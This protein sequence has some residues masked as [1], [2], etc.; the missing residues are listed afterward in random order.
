VVFII[1]F[2]LSLRLSLLFPFFFSS[3]SA[4][5]AAA[6]AAI[7][8]I[9]SS[10]FVVC[11]CVSIVPTLQPDVAFSN[12][13]VYHTNL[14]PQIDPVSR[15][16]PAFVCCLVSAHLFSSS[17]SSLLVSAVLSLSFSFSLLSLVPSPL[18][19]PLISFRRLDRLI[20]AHL[21]CT[22]LSVSVSPLRPFVS[23]AVTLCPCCVHSYIANITAAT[24]APAATYYDRCCRRVYLHLPALPYLTYPTLSYLLKF[25]CLPAAHYGTTATATATAAAPLFPSSLATATHHYLRCFAIYPCP[26]LVNWSLPGCTRRPACLPAPLRG[27]ASKGMTQVSCWPRQSETPSGKRRK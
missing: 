19:F 27:T 26:L 14:A 15:L 25:C 13:A 22:R 11:F 7:S 21:L 12:Q 16:C 3:S 5:A 10:S 1:P 9:S 24:T 4:V 18:H 2:Q 23:S 6:I 17:P 20:H 8:P